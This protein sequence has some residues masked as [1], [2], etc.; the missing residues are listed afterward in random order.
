[1]TRVVGRHGL[2]S[3]SSRTISCIMN[4]VTSMHAHLRSTNARPAWPSFLLSLTFTSHDTSHQRAILYYHFFLDTHAI[5]PDVDIIYPPPLHTAPYCTRTR[6]CLFVFELMSGPIHD[7]DAALSIPVHAF[8]RFVHTL[9]SDFLFYR[10][11][12][13]HHSLTLGKHKSS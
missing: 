5:A 6:T 8:K 2:D 12:F 7:A 1:M 11:T 10:W 3:R 13:I 4:H 9:H